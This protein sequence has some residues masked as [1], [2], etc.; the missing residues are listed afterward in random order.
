MLF[1][2]FS[3]LVSNKFLEDKI[4]SAIISEEEIS[5]KASPVLSDIRRKIR[6]ASSKAR[7]VLDKIIHSS[8]YIK[9][10]QD[11][12]VTQRDGR[13]VVPVRS[14][15]R[16]NVPG[17]VHDTSSSGATVFIEPMGVVQ[18]NND[19]KLLQSK[20]EQEIERILFELSANAGDFADSIIHSY[21]NLAQLNLIFAKADLA[22]SQIYSEAE[23]TIFIID[24]YIGLKTLVL[25]KSAAKNVSIVIFSDNIGNGL[26]SLEYND[27]KKE[28][29]NIT[30]SFRKTNG[31]FHDRY[32]ILDFDTDKEK[33]YHCG[34]S[35]K[36]AGNRVTTITEVPE[37]QVYH[38]LIKRIQNNPSLIL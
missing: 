20:E 13:Y 23:K 6:T 38:D 1:R 18:A 35:S 29:P 2:S 11:T 14:E 3:G 34:A 10:L 30:V 22:Y 32:I 24:N 19:I 21:K 37:K 4:T 16:G 8:T 36:D 33:I 5:D 28:Y 26:H 27:F 25:L 12:I 15:C 7:E 9:Y 17:L 31:M